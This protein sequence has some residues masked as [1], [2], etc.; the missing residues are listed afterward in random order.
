MLCNFACQGILNTLSLVE[1]LKYCRVPIS[2]DYMEKT[3]GSPGLNAQCI[4]ENSETN[5]WVSHSQEI[6][7][8]TGFHTVSK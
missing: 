1:M 6:T 8:T 4:E 7:G 3:M 2:A 5:S